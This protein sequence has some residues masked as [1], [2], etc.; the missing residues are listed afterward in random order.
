[1][2]GAFGMTEAKEISSFLVLEDRCFT[3]ELRETVS[4]PFLLIM[5]IIVSWFFMVF[6]FSLTDYQGLTTASLSLISGFYK[7]EFESSGGSE[8]PELC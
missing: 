5:P 4:I 2:L 1:M 8:C 6:P 7:H 3:Q